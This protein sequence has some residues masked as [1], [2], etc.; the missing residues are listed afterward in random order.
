[1]EK[2]I[3]M[4]PV[5]DIRVVNPR[6]RNVKKFKQVIDSIAHVGL[7]KP[8]TVSLRRNAA[9]GERRYD[10]VCG[11]GRLEAYMALHEE[12]IP[13]II[14]ESTKEDQL[15]MSL[16]ENLAR[17]RPTT[18]ELIKGINNMH[19]R[20]NTAKEIAEKTDLS[21]QYVSGLLGLWEHGEERLLQAVERGK[22]P[23]SVAITI[24]GCMDEEMQQALSKAY[25]EKKL[26]GKALLTARRLVEQRR[27]FGKKLRRNRKSKG[28]KLESPEKRPTA[29]SLV[30]AYKQETQKQKLFIKKA[31]L[32][33]SRLMF[34]IQA[35]RQLFKDE[36]F[37]NVLRAENLQ[38]LPKNLADQIKAR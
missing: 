24:S 21:E 22:I 4:V 31:K 33:E 36:N 30:R 34:V 14:V 9:E 6:F 35:V 10:L 13:A 37:V 32:C 25:E 29:D 3:E 15:L 11:Q 19:E 27:S 26:K 1:M 23:I 7:K 20:G 17:R 8:I 2:H 5:K 38:T 12:L 18:L 16:V 28:V